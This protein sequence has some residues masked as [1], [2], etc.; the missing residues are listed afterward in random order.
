RFAQLDP[1]LRWIDVVGMSAL[2][3]IGFTVSLLIAGIVFDADSLIGKSATLA[4]LIA[5]L[6]ATV[7]GAAILL[8]R[9]RWYAKSE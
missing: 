1:S 3:G 8:P 5:T 9:N 4:V 2:A 7:I 6:V